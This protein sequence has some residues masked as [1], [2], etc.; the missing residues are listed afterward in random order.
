MDLDAFHIISIHYFCSYIATHTDTPTS[1]T[2]YPSSLLPYTFLHLYEFASSCW[3]DATIVCPG[4]MA[5]QLL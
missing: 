1:C 5:V 2:L 4:A 3:G